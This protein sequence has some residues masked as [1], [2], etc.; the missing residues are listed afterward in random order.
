MISHVQHAFHRD[1]FLPLI[2]EDGRF[3]SLEKQTTEAKYDL[4]GV[5]FDPRGSSYA[6]VNGNVLELGDNINEYK[7][8]S[9]EEACVVLANGAQTLKLELKKEE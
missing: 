7:V 1:P 8:L 2:D 6:I 5:I 3:L 9:I 4:E